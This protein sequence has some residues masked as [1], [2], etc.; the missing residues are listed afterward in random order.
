MTT[1]DCIPA[2][3]LAG[4]AMAACAPSSADGPLVELDHVFILVQDSGAARSALS[5]AGI[6]LAT[7]TLTRH[8]G[9]G[10]ASMSALFENA[11]LEILWVDPQVSVN[12][13]AE[14]RV[15]SYREASAWRPDGPSPFGIGLRRARPGIDDFPYRGSEMEVGEWVEDG[16]TFFIFEPEDGESGAFIV[17]EYMGMPIWGKDIREEMPGLFQHGLGVRELTGVRL[18]VATPQTSVQEAGLPFIEFG[19][20]AEAPLLEL[21]F[22]NGRERA[23]TDLRPELP[24]VIHR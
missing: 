22:D 13:D 23:V 20:P 1:R 11:Y 15:A 24:L 12:D 7:S 5:D 17:P 8:D 3:A 10:T 16:E 2:V 9:S 19:D 4:L 18:N 14:A 6:L 21:E